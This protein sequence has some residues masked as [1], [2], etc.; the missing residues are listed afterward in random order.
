MAACIMQVDND[1]HWVKITDRSCRGSF[2][3]RSLGGIFK[4]KV[5]TILWTFS[6]LL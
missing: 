2:E 5:V 1:S 6:E 3:F 4:S